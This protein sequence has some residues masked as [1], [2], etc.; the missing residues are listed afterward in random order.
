MFSGSGVQSLLA[1]LITGNLFLCPVFSQ[2]VLPRVYQFH[3]SLQRT[4]FWINWIHLCVFLFEVSRGFLLL[5]FSKINSYPHSEFGNDFHRH[6]QPFW[7]DANPVVGK[8]NIQKG[9]SPWCKRLQLSKSLPCEWMKNEHSWAEHLWVTPWLFYQWCL[10][11][12]W[13]VSA[14]NWH[15][16]T[17]SQ[18]FALRVTWMH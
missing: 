16:R 3:W 2:P 18:P 4:S 7:L 9:V 6:E 13:K 12:G 15:R 8:V 1:F 10:G 14:G 17:A 5:L 11:R